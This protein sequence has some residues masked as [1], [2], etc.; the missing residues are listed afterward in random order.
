MSKSSRTIDPLND[1]LKQDIWLAVKLIENKRVELLNVRL[2]SSKESR[3]AFR[4]CVV[5]VFE[6][7]LP[8]VLS[9]PTKTTS[10]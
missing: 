3:V 5:E 9:K 10:K 6:R 8:T 4:G 7:V 2:K 1:L